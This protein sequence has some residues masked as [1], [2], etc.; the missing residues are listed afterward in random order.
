MELANIVVRG[1]GRPRLDDITLRFERAQVYGLIGPNGAGKSS[2]L[3]VITGLLPTDGGHMS[4]LPWQ[5]GRAVGAVF[6]DSGVHPGRTVRETLWL[7]ARYVDADSAQVTAAA[8]RTGLDNVMSRRVGALSLGMRMRL[9]IGVALL[10]EPSLVVLDEPTNGL[11]PNGITWVRG[12]VSDLRSAGATVLVSSHL[13]AELE[14]MIDTAI[15]MSRGRVARIHDH[16]FRSAE[17]CVIAVDR[18][19]ALMAALQDEG[20]PVTPG[21]SGLLVEAAPDAAVR[22]AVEVG[23]RVM[24]VSPRHGTLE[25]LY[26]A[27]SSAEHEAEAS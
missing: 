20:V 2:L 16:D 19:S 23:V 25:A 24:A 1:R 27:T 17:R 22:F 18:P 15:V 3:R 5:Q 21:A 14:P 4:G 6:G 7:R 13:L 12:V 11:D 26:E 9:A 8:R 10:G